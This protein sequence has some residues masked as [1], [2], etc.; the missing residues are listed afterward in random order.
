VWLLTGPVN[1]STLRSNWGVVHA[2]RNTQHP[3]N[4]DTSSAITDAINI[5]KNARDLVTLPEW[6]RGE[7]I[8]PEQSPA[9][10]VRRHDSGDR[11][12]PFT[13]K[14]RFRRSPDMP[15]IMRIRAR[16]P[17]PVEAVPQ[18]C[19]LITWLLIRVLTGL[20]LPFN[21]LGDVK[22]RN[23]SFVGGEDSG[24]VLFELPS[25]S[26]DPDQTVK[27]THWHQAPR[28]LTIRQNECS[29]SRRN[30]C[31]QSPEYATSCL[32][33][34][35]TFRAHAFNLP[36]MRTPNGFDQLSAAASSCIVAAH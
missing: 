35:S 22:E 11:T 33:L 27:S 34:E 10:Y 26:V 4:H 31:S 12:R 5:R 29:R 9:A 2:S 24:E 1:R 21:P 13:I 15:T 8:Q 20:F 32:L 25:A 30:H 7:T 19:N 14:A 23:V 17:R 3:F 18:G 28:M 6:R 36:S 16:D